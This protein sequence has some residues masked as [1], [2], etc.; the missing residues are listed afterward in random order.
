MRRDL[1]WAQRTI[2][3]AHAVANLVFRRR[4]EL[5][6]GSWGEYGPNFV[7]YGVAGEGE[8]LEIEKS[9]SPLAVSFHEP[10]LGGRLTAIAYLG[11][12]LERFNELSLL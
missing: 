11:P 12:P 1:P 8:L 6:P 9:L 2:Q 5:D 4:D 3:A 7:V 10:D